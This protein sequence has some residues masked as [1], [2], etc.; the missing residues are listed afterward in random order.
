MLAPESVPMLVLKERQAPRCACKSHTGKMSRV[1]Q[2]ASACPAGKHWPS[3]WSFW[4]F[5]RARAQA[6]A[7]AA[8]RTHDEGFGPDGGPSG[9]QAAAGVGA[10]GKLMHTGRGHSILTQQSIQVGAALHLRGCKPEATEHVGGCSDLISVTPQEQDGKVNGTVPRLHESSI[11][12]AVST[13]PMPAEPVPGTCAAPGSLTSW[14]SCCSI[15]TGL[16]SPVGGLP[17]P[18]QLFTSHTDS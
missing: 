2:A 12:V 17:R 6:S 11:P 18:G 5:L 8:E 14:L 10:L 7:E 13:G 4:N 9:P 3:L 16:G 15:L 1:R